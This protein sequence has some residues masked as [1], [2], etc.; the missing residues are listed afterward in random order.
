[1]IL[2][3]Q[4]DVGKTHLRSLHLHYIWK[5]DCFQREIYIVPILNLKPGHVCSI[6]FDQ[7]ESEY[8]YN[9]V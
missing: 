5:S 4:A 2:D 7:E 8:I 6:H 9:T 1:M 3:V